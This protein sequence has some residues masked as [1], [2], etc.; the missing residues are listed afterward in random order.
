MGFLP[1]MTSTG[2]LIVLSEAD[3]LGRQD[4]HAARVRRW[5]DP[6]QARAS[7]GEKHPVYDFLFNYYASVRPGC[8]AGIRDRTSRWRDRPRTPFC[9]GPNTASPRKA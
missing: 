8:A 9:A 4:Q 1:D 5:T 7:R 6:H 2:E 3:W